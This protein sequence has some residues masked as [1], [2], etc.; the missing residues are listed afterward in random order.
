[1]ITKALPFLQGVTAILLIILILLQQ[2][3]A[4][5]GGAFGGSGTIYRSRRG[6]EK[7]LFNFTVFLA[8][9]FG[10]VIILDLIV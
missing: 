8:L 3:G 4:A 1:M 10:L 7:V 9:L 6:V 2:R 5:L